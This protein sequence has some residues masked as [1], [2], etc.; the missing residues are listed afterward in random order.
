MVPV[1]G[2]RSLTY[3]RQSQSGILVN[4]IL[5]PVV[6]PKG[7]VLWSKIAA[8]IEEPDFSVHQ[9]TCTELG[10]ELFVKSVRVGNAKHIRVRPRFDNWKASGTIAVM[11]EGITTQVLQDILDNAGRDCGLGEWRPSSPK[12]PGPWGTFTAKIEA[13]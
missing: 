6:V 4:E 11:D 9:S 12:A 1:P 2:K 7:M 13:V 8:L 10:F 3:K 5:W